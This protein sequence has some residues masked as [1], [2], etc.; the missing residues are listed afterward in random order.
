[1]YVM[2]IFVG[3]NCYTTKHYILPELNTNIPVDNI[4]S[5]LLNKYFV[6]DNISKFYK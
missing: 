6:R 1:M 4:E 2:K 3:K 5:R